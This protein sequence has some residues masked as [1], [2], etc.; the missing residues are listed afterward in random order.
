MT[1]EGVYRKSGGNGQVKQI[2]SGFEKDSNYNIS[3]PDLDIH[4][5]TSCLKQYFRKLPNPLITFEVYDSVLEAAQLPDVDR[6]C[7]A[8][9]MALGALAPAHRD[10]LEYLI[11]HL[12]RIVEKEALNLVSHYYLFY[13]VCYSQY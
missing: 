11:G 7:L 6:R 4:A 1:V 12:A 9:K 2:Q 8:M 10:V 3:D 5:V 13:F